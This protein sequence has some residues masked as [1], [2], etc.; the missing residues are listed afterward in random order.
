MATVIEI[1]TNPA[2]FFIC[3]GNGS[4]AFPCDASNLD[5]GDDE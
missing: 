1:P 4:K 2:V 3:A 5:S